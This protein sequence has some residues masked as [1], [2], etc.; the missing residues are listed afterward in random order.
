MNA[1]I[2]MVSSA[3]DEEGGREG[4]RA[5]GRCG[6]WARIDILCIAAIGLGDDEPRCK[7]CAIGLRGLEE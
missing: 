2:M 4:E 1:M 6:E 3:R 7:S 5:D